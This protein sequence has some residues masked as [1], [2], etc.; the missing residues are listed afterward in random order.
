LTN[1]KGFENIP[2]KLG[3]LFFT[4]TIWFRSLANEWFGELGMGFFS[5]LPKHAVAFLVVVLSRWIRSD[6]CNVML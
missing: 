5:T 6:V 1:P 4:I 2:L 3:L